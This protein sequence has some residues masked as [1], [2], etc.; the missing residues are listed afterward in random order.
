MLKLPNDRYI[1]EIP[2]GVRTITG[3][4][5]S[6]TAFIGRT[7]RGSE[8]DPVAILSLADFER[9]FGGLD[10]DYPLTFAV[11]DFFQNGGNLGLIVRLKKDPAKAA[12][13]FLGEFFELRAVNTGIWGNNLCAAVDYDGIDDQVAKRFEFDSKGD[14]FNLTVGEYLNG[15]FVTIEHFKNVAWNKDTTSPRRLDR[16]LEAESSLVMVVSLPVHRPI[17]ASEANCNDGGP[18]AMTS[19]GRTLRMESATG[20]RDSAPLEPSDIIGSEDGKTGLYALDKADL[21]NLVCIPPDTRNGDVSGDVYREAMQYCY[22]R[23]AFLIVDSPH[24]WGENKVG[25]VQRVTDGLAILGFTEERA[26]NAAIFFPRVVET[27]PKRENQLD[28]FVSCGLIAGVFS[29]TDVTRG[30]WK[31]P[32]GLETPLRGIRDLQ[33][34]LDDDDNKML[35]PLGINCLRRFPEGIVVWGSRTLRGADHF[36]DDYK[37]I[38]VRRLALFIEE[39]L[40]RGT[41]WVVFEPNDEPLW[42]QIRLNVGAFMQGLFRQGAFAGNTPR[43]AFFVKCDS[44]TTTQEEINNGVVNYLV[45]FAPLK[46]AEFL[47][48][49]I[50]QMAG[51]IPS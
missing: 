23:R 34:S 19:M 32:A 30:V 44:E 17:E 13:I 18:T 4:A 29:H 6:I 16:V 14:L 37:Y 3:V 5:T 8:N 1:E 28:T 21:F 45:G 46:P 41:K 51:Q 31:A 24:S 33:I 7:P 40:Y 50:Q 15:G 38:P 2:S 36:G 48:I 49:E 47:F 26:R 35:N 22:K 10:A 43:N 11:Q 9:R 12:S 42:A 27:D 25:V 20:G 39:S